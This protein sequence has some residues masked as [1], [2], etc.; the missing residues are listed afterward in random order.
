MAGEARSFLDPAVHESILANV[1]HPLGGNNSR[2][3][4]YLKVG[5]YFHAVGQRVAALQCSERKAAAP[6][7]RISEG[8]LARQ[9]ASA[10]AKLPMGGWELVNDTTA[11]EDAFLGALTCNR[12]RPG[13]AGDSNTT[14]AKL[15]S[16]QE[17]LKA[18][19]QV[20]G[21]PRDLSIAPRKPEQKVVGQHIAIQRGWRLVAAYEARQ[22]MRFDFVV[23]C[24]PDVFYPEPLRTLEALYA[25]A[26]ALAARQSYRR[27]G[28]ARLG[29]G[30]SS[31][32]HAPVIVS[33]HGVTKESSTNLFLNDMFW[34]APRRLAWPLFNGIELMRRC[35]GRRV[36]AAAF[37]CCKG[38]EM[39]LHCAL[40]QGQQ[41]PGHCTALPTAAGASTTLLSGVGDAATAPD[42][43]AKMGAI[44]V[45]GVWVLHLLERGVAWPCGD[46]A[47][48]RALQSKSLHKNKFKPKMTG[49]SS[50]V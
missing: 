28:A 3:F 39:L 23:R 4:A 14:M 12:L 37:D 13:G 29:P 42:L 43:A 35:G 31:A 15:K 30:A 2:V 34:V 27:F 50:I 1:V 32:G 5:V 19:K 11:D 6:P 36:P 9:L 24:R 40:G 25:D 20:N 48:W 7:A 21:A 17:L 45:P 10:M 41:G 47:T 49:R 16:G 44:M 46:E 38:S 18:G 33:Q 22:R 26:S 8:A